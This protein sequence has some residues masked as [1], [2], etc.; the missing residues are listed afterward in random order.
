MG[1]NWEMQ[2]KINERNRKIKQLEQEL[3]EARKPNFAYSW[4][5]SND[6]KLKEENDTL[7]W[8]LGFHEEG[9]NIAYLP[10]VGR[11]KSESKE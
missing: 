3:I 8:K 11:T 7:K 1:W 2:S 9:K 6:K 5:F 10:I 4:D